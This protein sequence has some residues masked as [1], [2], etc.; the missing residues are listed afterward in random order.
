MSKCF[1]QSYIKDNL[2]QFG[3]IMMNFTLARLKICIGIGP[4]NEKIVCSGTEK[5]GIDYRDL[6]ALVTKYRRE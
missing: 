5:V 4:I 2:Y 1:F 6:K 3:F